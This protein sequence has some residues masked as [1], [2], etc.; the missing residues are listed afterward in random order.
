MRGL[1]DAIRRITERPSD[2]VAKG[3]ITSLEIARTALGARNAVVAGQVPPGVPLGKLGNGSLFPGIPYVV[4]PATSATTLRFSR[5]S[6]GC[7]PPEPFGRHERMVCRRGGSQKVRD[8][9][10]ALVPLS[11]ITS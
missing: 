2:V 10:S 8:G 1:C 9:S 7:I 11:C 3:G 6:A 4:F 5:S